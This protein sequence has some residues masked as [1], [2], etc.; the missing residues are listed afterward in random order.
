MKQIFNDVK[1]IDHVH[2]LP[3]KK[4]DLIQTLCHTKCLTTD[5]SISM[6]INTTNNRI[7]PCFYCKNK[8]EIQEGTILFA[9]N[10]FHNSC[11]KKFGESDNE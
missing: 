11:W 9:S 2:P 4:N 3:S 10:W 8:M 6:E 5:D 7:V 1:N